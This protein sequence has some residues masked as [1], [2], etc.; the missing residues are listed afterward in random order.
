MNTNHGELIDYHHFLIA[1]E[2]RTGSFRKAIALMVRPGDVV[3]DIGTGTGIL[4]FFACQA[5]ARKVYAI[6]ASPIIELAQVLCEKNGFQDRVVFL[7]DFSFNV[8]LPE[9]ANVVVSD[10][11]AIFGLQGG[12]LGA[13]I[14]ARKRMLREGAKVIPHV[15]GLSIAPV[16]VPEM[17]G[18]LGFWCRDLYDLDLSPIRPFAMANTY[19][20]KF[21]LGDLLSTP[22]PL[23]RIPFSTAES[24][25]VMGSASCV[26]TRAGVMHGIGGWSTYEFA[27]GISFTNS[28]ANPTAHWAHCFFP[29]QAPTPLNEG[30]LVDVTISTKDGSSWRWQVKI[31]P[32]PGR[33]GTALAEMQF[34]QA[35]IFGFPLSKRKLEE[36]GR[37]KLS[38]KGEAEIF[39]LGLMDGQR[40]VA[41]LENEL[42]ARYGDCFPSSA[43]AS[44]FLKEIVSRNS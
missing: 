27:P 32:L 5:G 18:Q 4:A 42:V 9:L 14:D 28:P 38:R 23:A 25:Y 41:D 21:K 43:A 10:T 2:G 44:A 6:E 8:S 29:M 15:V 13:L 7:R 11:G 19:N 16:E 3:V 12:Q 31:T 24:T 37:P 36:R 20:T 40:T 22:T 33:N 34:G 26:T 30:D 1:D 17:Y 39:L 35:D